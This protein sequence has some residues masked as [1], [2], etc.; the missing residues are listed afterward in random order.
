LD[1]QDEEFARNRKFDENGNLIAPSFDTILNED[2]E[3]WPSAVDLGVIAFNKPLSSFAKA[4]FTTLQEIGSFGIK[5]K[6]RFFIVYFAANDKFRCL[7]AVAQLCIGWNDF[8]QDEC[9]LWSKGIVS[10]LFRGAR[11]VIVL[12]SL[13]T[14]QFTSYGDRC[15]PPLVRA[16]CVRIPEEEQA[17]FGLTTLES[18]NVITNLGA[19]I[20]TECVWSEYVKRESTSSIGIDGAIGL[21]TLCESH[22]EVDSTVALI[23]PF[24]AAV[25]AYGGESVL[26][27]PKRIR[28]ACAKIKDV[29]SVDRECL[30]I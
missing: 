3:T 28:A 2:Y 18:G 27:E 17:D 12:D 21:L 24:C 6:K 1:D 20:I 14:T 5:S 23:S 30:Y 13:Q 4:C 22:V 16:L 10:T 11:R 29:R 9:F 26:V 25:K 19:A 8:P 15:Y 7:L